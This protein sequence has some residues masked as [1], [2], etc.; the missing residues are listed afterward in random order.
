MKCRVDFEIVGKVL[1]ILLLILQ[2]GILD[3]YLVEHHEFRSLGFITTDVIVL[4]VWIGVIFLAK[5]KW[6]LKL[7]KRRQR[8]GE[9]DGK[10]SDDFGD[11]IPYAFVAWFAYVAITLVPE[12]SVIFKRFADQLGD[13]KVF[14]QNILKAA[15]CITP[16]LFLLLVNSHHDAKPNYAR[17]LYL[18]KLSASVTLD[19]LDSIDILEILFMD[20]E[21]LNLPVDLENAIIAF[22]CINFFLPTLALLELR[23]ASV[24]GEAR[25]IPYQLLY[26]ISYIFLVNVPF[27][28]IRIVLWY[29]YE[30]DVSVFIGKNIIATAIYA[31][32]IYESC[33]PHRPEKCPTCS[34]HFTPDCI[35]GHRSLCGS[36]QEGQDGSLLMTSPVSEDPANA[37]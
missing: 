10:P 6:L 8:N 33:G 1:C 14:G 24:K 20:D 37:V 5:R 11:E 21:K 27:G 23:V 30:Q 29:G 26:S 35:D 17:K 9:T 34:R 19:I 2:G 25:S 18:D 15:L 3:Y 12:V 22:A 13:A 28:V 7:K 32:D 36:A 31:L 16:M 4:A